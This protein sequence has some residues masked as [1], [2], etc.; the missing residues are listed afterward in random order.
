MKSG[1]FY[2]LHKH[3]IQRESSSLTGDTDSDEKMGDVVESTTDSTT[4][5]TEARVY[6]MGRKTKIGHCA[7]V[8]DLCDVENLPIEGNISKPHMTILYSRSGLRL[9]KRFHWLYSLNFLA[10]FS[11]ESIE[12]VLDLCE[13][14]RKDKFAGAKISFR[15]QKWGPSSD[16]I[17]GKLQDFCGMIRTIVQEEWGWTEIDNRIPHVALRKKKRRRNK[18]N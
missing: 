15:L 10:G 18:R 16:K 4:Y 3:L 14:I 2:K 1:R 5:W 9:S 13:Q 17:V 7:I 6:G 11:K 12:K 8:A